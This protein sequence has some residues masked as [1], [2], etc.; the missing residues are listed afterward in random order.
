MVYKARNWQ[1]FGHWAAKREFWKNWDGLGVG[2]GGDPAGAWGW[3]V[4]WRAGGGVVGACGF[5][6][7]MV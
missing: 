2:L 1:I 6:T 7:G 5:V 4:V 3:P